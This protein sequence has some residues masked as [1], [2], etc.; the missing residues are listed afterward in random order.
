MARGLALGLLLACA[1]MPCTM[2]AEAAGHSRPS[3]QEALNAGTR[4]WEKGKTDEALRLWAE[5]VQAM[6]ASRVLLFAGIYR[7]LAYARETYARIAPTKRAL[8][9]RA[10]FR[11]KPAYYVLLAPRN[12]REDARLRRFLHTRLAIRWP[13]G[14]EVAFFQRRLP[15]SPVRKAGSRPVRR[16]PPAKPPAPLP[17][18]PMQA[19]RQLA[20][21]GKRKESLQLLARLLRTRPRM[22]EARLL[23]ARLWLEESRPQEALLA[24]APLLATRPRDWRPWFWQGAALLMLGRAREAAEALDEA[25]AR[26]GKVGRIWLARAVAALEQHEPQAA[27]QML[28]VAEALQPGL[29]ETQLNMALAYE[30]LGDRREATAAY[31]S[32]L[33]L[34]DRADPRARKA[35]LVHLLALARN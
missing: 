3:E 14:K 4:A 7:K 22:K 16:A 32:Y 8:V 34:A 12:K 27:L 11:G 6:P 21:Q 19:A 30:M 9:L 15:A 35:A 33:R 26:N 5:G 17:A 25:V 31:R 18:R 23:Y 20:E 13:R 28:A 24:L 1:F 29:P 2:Q 10:P